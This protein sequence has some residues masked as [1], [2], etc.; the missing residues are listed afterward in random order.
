MTD[1]SHTMGSD[2]SFGPT[3]ALVLASG[4]TETTQRVARRLVT[5]LGGY[6]WQ[7]TYGGSF[8]KFVGATVTADQIQA[9]AQQQMLLEPSVLQSPPSTVTTSVDQTGN[10]TAIITFTTAEGAQSLIV[11][12]SNAGGTNITWTSFN[13]DTQPL[14]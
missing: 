3:G 10:I 1:I 7:I 13:P 8:P 14:A 5:N 4:L 6:I 2:L 12:I 11:P 9:I